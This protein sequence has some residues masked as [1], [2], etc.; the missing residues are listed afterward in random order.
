VRNALLP[1]GRNSH[2]DVV[3][4]GA[5]HAGVQVAATLAGSFEGSIAL[6]SAEQ[7]EPYEKP[8]LTK[9]F[10][11]GEV[12]EHD[13]LLKPSAYWHT[14]GLALLLGQR[15]TLVDAENHVV[16]TERGDQFSYGSLVWSAGAH[17]V[18]IGLP[19]TDL[20]G[21]HELRTLDDTKRFRREVQPGSKVVVVGG[22][23]VGLEA[24]SA[25]V[26]LG[27]DV[28]ILESQPRLLARV[29]GPEVANYLLR[30][31][32]DSGARVELNTS[33]AAIGERNGRASGVQ[34]DDGREIP[35]DVVLVSVGIRPTVD[36]LAAAGARCS[37]GVEVDRQG[38]TSLLDVFAAG[39][40][41][42]FPA[43]GGT[44]VR[45][46]SLQNAVEQG[47]VVA[48]S[49]MGETAAHALVPYFWSN[50]Y[51]IKLKTIGLFNG[52]DDV[53][54]RNSADP[55]SFSVIYLREGLVCAVDSINAMKDYVDARRVLGRHLLTDVAQDA[56][57]RLRDA[58]V[59]DQPV[60]ASP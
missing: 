29:T 13:L 57:V 5:G 1:D 7:N 15:V 20:S 3:V 42:C 41:T 32:R 43:D 33:V 24:A 53:V 27:A 48:K 38:R 54:V 60:D 31:H 17:P 52:Y 49:L 16:V 28:T 30:R 39:D 44:T 9:G 2:Y 40:C 59:A 56:A 12:D 18:R 50:Q 23:Y 25:C 47:E 10:L 21:V 22:G 35:A 14:S 34:L 45:L 36:V 11:T 19:T 8:P 4:V 37:N 26:K 55:D 46:E 6:L 51:D 58:T